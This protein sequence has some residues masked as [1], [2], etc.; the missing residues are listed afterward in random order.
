M[1]DNELRMTEVPDGLVVVGVASEETVVTKATGFVVSQAASGGMGRY[2]GSRP[3][4]TAEEI[5]QLAYSF[6]EARGRQD[7]HATEDWL[8]AEKLLV[9]HYA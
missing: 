3:G 1:R 8:R 6:Y 9:H 2:T 5:A 4:P 7:G